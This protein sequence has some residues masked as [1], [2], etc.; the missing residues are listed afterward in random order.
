MPCHPFK[1]CSHPGDPASCS[2]TTGNSASSPSFYLYLIALYYNKVHRSCQNAWKKETN[3]RQSCPLSSA[4]L[5]NG[6]QLIG[7]NTWVSF[8]ERGLLQGDASFQVALKWLL[9]SPEGKTSTNQVEN[10]HNEHR[11]HRLPLH[12]CVGPRCRA[13]RVGVHASHNT[14]RAR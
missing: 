14:G 13:I 4:Y 2:T 5:D 10:N 6:V 7:S 1:L 3:T 9:Q 8:E 12:H 11:Q